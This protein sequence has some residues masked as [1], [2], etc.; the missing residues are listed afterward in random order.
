MD[1]TSSSNGTARQE[2]EEVVKISLAELDRLLLDSGFKYQAKWSRVRE[3]YKYG[4]F[5]VC[6][7]KNAG[8]GYLVEFESIIEDKSKVG[9]TKK[10]L[11]EEIKKFD[12][13]ELDQARLARMFDH[14][15]KHW[16]EYY[17]TDKVFNVE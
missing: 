2:F 6:L 7:D 14:Y 9:E 8:Y 17:G 13:I 12:L 3:Q 10:R 15:N 11:R 1:D 4:D 5:N 16:P